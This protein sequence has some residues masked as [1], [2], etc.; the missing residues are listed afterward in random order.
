MNKEVLV[1]GG[2]G[3]IGKAISDKFSSKI[4]DSIGSKDLDLSNLESIDAFFIKNK[5]KYKIF[6]FCSGDND[7]DLI[8]QSNF[9]KFESTARINYQCLS[10]IFSSNYS[11]L[12]E[13]RSVVAISSLYGNLARKGRSSYVSSKH[14]LNGFIKNL[15]IEMAPKINANLVS[16]GFVLTK[17]TKKNNSPKKLN[18]I[19]SMIP[20]KRFANSSEVASL[21]YF[22]TT[23]EASYITGSNFIIYGGFS[24]GGFQNIIDYE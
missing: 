18:K 15:A 12:K 8:K 5:N 20:M 7:P 21:A 22:L 6:V 3:D 1:I 14:A 23:K 24:S 10:Y 17:M 9:N 11:C 19:K 2:T 16:P 4:T 13:L